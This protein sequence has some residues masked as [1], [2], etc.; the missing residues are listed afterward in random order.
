MVSKETTQKKAG[1]GETVFTGYK[2]KNELIWKENE[3][4]QFEQSE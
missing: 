2:D 4:L 3:T 1:K